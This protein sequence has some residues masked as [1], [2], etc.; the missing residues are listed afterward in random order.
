MAQWKGHFDEIVFKAF[1]KSL[2]IYLIGSMVKLESGR[3]T[4]VINQSPESFLTPMVKVFFSTKTLSHES[5]R[6]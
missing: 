3:L 4:V 1:V 2:G 5:L 6:L